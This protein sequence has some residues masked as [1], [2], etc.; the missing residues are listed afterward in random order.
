MSKTTTSHFVKG[1]A[2]PLASALIIGLT[3]PTLS[4]AFMT[5]EKVKSL[6]YM[7]QEQVTGTVTSTGE[8]LVGVTVSVKENPSVATSTDDNG[9]FTIQATKGQTLV[10]RTIGFQ[11]VEHIVD[12]STMQVNLDAD[13]ETIDEVVVV[14]FGT[15][16][17]ENLTGA[18][19]SIDSKDLE[20]RP[21]TNVSS[22][23]Q[24]KFAGVTIIQNS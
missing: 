10:F 23:L 9:Q 4:H 17:K 13:N 14:G 7:K 20:D 11:S 12:G 8:P 5:F 3:T 6:H 16:K 24:G 22:A 18:V 21:V 15:Q 19:Q 2:F 1:R